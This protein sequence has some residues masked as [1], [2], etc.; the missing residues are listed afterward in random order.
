[1][2]FF[3]KSLAFALTKNTKKLKELSVL[4]VR[5][6]KLVC[7]LDLYRQ[8]NLFDIGSICNQNHNVGCIK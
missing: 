1:M 8:T 6:K 7:E 3:I 2:M 4:G 5:N